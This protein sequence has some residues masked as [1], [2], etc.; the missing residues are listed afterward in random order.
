MSFYSHIFS[1]FIF[2]WNNVKENIVKISCFMRCALIFN[3]KI[4]SIGVKYLLNERKII[5][6]NE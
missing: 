1:V 3:E 4:K 2:L 6:N 5:E